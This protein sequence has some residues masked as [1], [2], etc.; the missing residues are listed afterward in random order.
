M[1]AAAALSAQPVAEEVYTIQQLP[2]RSF[3]EEAWEKAIEGIDY[4]KDM[5]PKKES[6]T[7][8]TSQKR[9]DSQVAR[10]VFKFGIILGGIALL[11]I[12]LWYA[13]SKNL[14]GRAQQTQGKT[15]TRVALEKLEENLHNTDPADYLQQAISEGRFNLALRLYY[16]MIIRELSLKKIIQWKR[17]KTNRDYLQEAQSSSFFQQFGEVTRIFERSWYGEQLLEQQEFVQLQ[18]ELEQFIQQIKQSDGRR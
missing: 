17:D 18:P 2:P 11:A 6:L 5:K 10:T 15:T 13:F 4:S 9:E 16:L 14:S 8:S 3:D 7:D 1:L 12:V